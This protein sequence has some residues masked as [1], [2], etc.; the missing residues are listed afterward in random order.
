LCGLDY[1]AESLQLALCDRGQRIIG[2]PACS[3]KA[4]EPS[5]GIIIDQVWLIFAAGH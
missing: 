5:H 2:L 4:M 3:L 1:P